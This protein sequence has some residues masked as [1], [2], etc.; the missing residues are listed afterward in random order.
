MRLFL[1]SM[2]VVSTA[3]WSAGPAEK[4]VIAK[5]TAAPRGR[6][7]LPAPSYLSPTARQLIKERMRRHRGDALA[8]LKAVLFLDH[9]TVERL[10][11]ELAAEP[12][13]TRPIAG[14]AD[15]LNAALPERFFVLQDEL[16][17]RALELGAAAKSPDDSLMAARLGELTQT[18][19]SCHSAYL[20]PTPE[21]AP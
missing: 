8:L 18:C 3:G 20:A 13:L 4:A 16:R 12:R 9:A 14:G 17:T 11:A 10:A 1:I 6:E 21:A 7:G 19:V 15:D 5:K 2:I